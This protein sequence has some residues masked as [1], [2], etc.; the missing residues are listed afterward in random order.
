MRQEGQRAGALVIILSTAKSMEWSCDQIVEVVQGAQG[1]NAKGRGQ[2]RKDLRFLLCLPFQRLKKKTLVKPRESL[3]DARGGPC[4]IKRYR[5]GGGRFH[6]SRQVI[7]ALA[8]KL[9]EDV[10]AE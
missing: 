1:R 6:V 3:I 7:A 10:P 2:I 9:Q 4:E 8:E 5:D